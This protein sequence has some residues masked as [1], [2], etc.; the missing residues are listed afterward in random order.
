MHE[1]HPVFEAPSNADIPIWRYMNLAKF[2]SM[3]QDEALHFARVDRMID[4]FEGSISTPT[5]S[6]R[7]ASLEPLENLEEVNAFYA[8]ARKE[9][10]AYI[11]LN[12]W[13]MNE[14]ESAA[15]W[16]LYLGGEAQGIAIRSTYRRL[17]KSITEQ[18]EVFIGTVHYVDFN[19]EIVPE[20]NALNP[21]VYKRRSFE[22]ERELRALHVGH[23]LADD[24]VKAAPLGLDVVPITVDLNPLVEA[25]YVSPKAKNW[26]ERLIRNELGR[27][28]RNWEVIHS[29]LDA[30]PIY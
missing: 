25:V 3:L 22:H 17:S 18:R 19:T 10:R 30:D 14:H 8:E 28:R 12:C 7:R 11:Y 24:E 21:Y 20:R 29:N 27:Y 5:L 4:E 23:Q 16:D 13:H 15:M 6:V 1:P 26:F 2:L 9:F